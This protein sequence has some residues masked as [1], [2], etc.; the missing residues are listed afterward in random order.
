MRIRNRVC[1]LAL[2]LVL[3][4]GQA[5]ADP[6][7]VWKCDFRGALKSRTP[8]NVSREGFASAPVYFG[9][10]QANGQITTMEVRGYDDERDANVLVR[11][12]I[13]GESTE[14]ANCKYNVSG[15][16]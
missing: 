13:K 14:F 7:H 12:D 1:V 15:G 9:N 5:I 10:A 3:G 2:F 16:S 4:T 8:F 6:L 11:N